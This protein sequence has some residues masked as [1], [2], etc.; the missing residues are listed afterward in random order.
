MNDV[1]GENMKE[2]RDSQ[3][4]SINQNDGKKEKIINKADIIL[5]LS[6]IL[7]C[8][9]FLLVRKIIKKPGYTV[10]IT[11]AGEVVMEVPLSE[12]AEY[13]ISKSEEKYNIVKVSDGE[14]M[15]TDAN[16][17]DHICM[18]YEDVDSV[19]ETIICLPHKMVIEVCE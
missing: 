16:C 11:V 13:I 4:E 2:K 12:D 9:V 18:N 1:S 19:G 10:K 17:R 5:G 14:V 7:I 6:I 8:A 15:V 3:D